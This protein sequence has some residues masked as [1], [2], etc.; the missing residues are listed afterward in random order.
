M[1]ARIGIAALLGGVIGLEREAHGRAAGLRTHIL[2]CV[3]ASLVMAVTEAFGTSDAPG[4]ALAGIVTGIGFLGAGAIVRTHDIVRGLTTAACVWLVAGLGIVV[5]KGLYIL[6]G[7]TTLVALVVLVRLSRIEQLIPTLSYHVVKIQGQRA[8]A[9]DL[10]ERCRGVLFAIGYRVLAVTLDLD[11]AKDEATLVLHV[12]VRGEPKVV[13][14][15]QD[16]LALPG[17]TRVKWDQA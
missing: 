7:G 13:R 8:M 11:Q 15:G 6:A 4:R 10:E 1:L 14:V 5:G 16:L 17:V 2:V 12:R 3:G 9:S